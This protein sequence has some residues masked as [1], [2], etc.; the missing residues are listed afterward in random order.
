[1]TAVSFRADEAQDVLCRRCLIPG[2]GWTW[3]DVLRCEP[4]H[5]A[6]YGDEA[7]DALILSDY[8]CFGEW[9]TDEFL[10]RTGCYMVTASDPEAVTQ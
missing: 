3:E 1:M 7:T 4:C 8:S 5:R 6:V 9:W 2:R 10:D